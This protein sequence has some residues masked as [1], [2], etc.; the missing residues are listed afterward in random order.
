MRPALSKCVRRRCVVRDSIHPRPQRTSA[1]VMAAA[2][3]E[4]EVDLLEK[5]LLSVRICLVSP[6]QSLECM[7]VV[8]SGFFVKLVLLG[9]WFHGI[10]LVIGSPQRDACV[11]RKCGVKCNSRDYERTALLRSTRL[12][13]NI[14]CP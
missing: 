9:F 2:L 10:A 4:C 7:A 1:F 11:T 3:P 8:R 5:I 6:D 12:D 14:R 13:R